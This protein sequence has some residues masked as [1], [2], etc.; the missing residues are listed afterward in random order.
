MDG[1]GMTPTTSDI[2]GLANLEDQSYLIIKGL[3]IRNYQASNASS[4]PAGIYDW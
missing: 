1:A 3:E 2:R 4:T